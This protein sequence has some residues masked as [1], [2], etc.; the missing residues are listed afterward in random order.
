MSDPLLTVTADLDV[1]GET[2]RQVGVFG[3]WLLC[4]AAAVVLTAAR[5]PTSSNMERPVAEED[6]T[7]YRRERLLIGGGVGLFLPALWTWWLTHRRRRGG[8]HARGITVDITSDAELRVWGRGY[9]QRIALDGADV[10]ERLVDVF[11]GR[12]G[13]W[14]Q[15]RLVVRAHKPLPGMPTELALATPSA[16]DDLDLD[17]GLIGGEG[18]CLELRRDDYL[19]I[20]D[21]LRE[22]AHRTSEPASD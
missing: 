4:L 10:S 19:R 22:I 1:P 15:R 20:L 14:R 2:R 8:P 11:T 3:I 13:A 12:L 6:M 7:T 16:D 17:L 5:R 21:T 9:G 18:D